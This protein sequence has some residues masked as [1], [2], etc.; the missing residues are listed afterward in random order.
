[1]AATIAEG[2]TLAYGVFLVGLFAY[3]VLRPQARRSRKLRKSIA[4]Y[5]GADLR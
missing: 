4:P 5:K 2:L 1:M 3:K